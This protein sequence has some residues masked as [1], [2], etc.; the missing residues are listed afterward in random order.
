MQY[1]ADVLSGCRAVA[2]AVAPKQFEAWGRVRESLVVHV[3]CENFE[4]GTWRQ[5]MTAEPAVADIVPGPPGLTMPHC[6]GSAEQAAAKV[7]EKFAAVV[8]PE[9][10]FHR[11]LQVATVG[12]DHIGRVV[13]QKRFE[14]I[15]LET[16]RHV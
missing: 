8:E 12:P 15:S 7:I 9:R 5:A 16:S 4:A 2:S 3:S 14:T 13:A 11:S 10:D 6:E 1:F